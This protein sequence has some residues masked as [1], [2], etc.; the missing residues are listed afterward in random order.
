MFDEYSFPHDSFLGRD[1][2]VLET[3]VYCSRA[4]QGVDDVEVDR[5]IEEA[6]RRNIARDITGILVFESGVFFQWV[7]GPPSE[8]QKLA[9]SLSKDPRHYDVVQL[10]RSAEKRERLYPKWQMEH[11]KAEELREILQEALVS[12][13]NQSNSLALKRIISCIDSGTFSATRSV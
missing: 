7:E 13:E 11:V 5:L 3:F 8:V 4:A 2:P 12:A 1:A 10:E 9:A 6:Q